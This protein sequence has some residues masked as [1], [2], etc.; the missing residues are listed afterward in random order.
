MTEM[1]KYQ[2]HF[3]ESEKETFICNGLQI[4]SQEVVSMAEGA[5]GRWGEWATLVNTLL[6][7]CCCYLAQKK[8]AESCLQQ[9]LFISAPFSAPYLHWYNSFS[10]ECLDRFGQWGGRKVPVD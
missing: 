4:F 5:G 10:G 1:E 6:S 8:G 9:F 2:I 7:L 3:L